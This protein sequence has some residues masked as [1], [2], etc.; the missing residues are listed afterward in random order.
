M[1]L[2]NAVLSLALAASLFAADAAVDKAKKQIGE[3]KYDDAITGLEAAYKAKPKS[4]ELKKA[5]AD[6]YLAKADALMNDP[7]APPRMKYPGALR[8]YRSVLQYD[9]SNA[10]A[11]QNIKTI[12]DIYKSMGRPVPQ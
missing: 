11:Q 9:A 7:A 8:A 4:P 10:K 1:M 6:A 12:E 5:L 3:K 2:R